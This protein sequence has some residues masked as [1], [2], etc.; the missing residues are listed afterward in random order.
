MGHLPLCCCTSTCAIKE[1]GEWTEENATTC[2]CTFPDEKRPYIFKPA[3]NKSKTFY[4][5]SNGASKEVS[6]GDW[7]NFWFKGPERYKE[8]TPRVPK[9]QAKPNSNHSPNDYID[10]SFLLQTEDEN[11]HFVKLGVEGYLR[12]E[13]NL[14]AFLACC[15]C[16]FVLPN[17]KL[18][19]IRPS[20][21]KIASLMAHGE[22]VNILM[23][24]LKGINAINTSIL[25]GSVN[26]FI[27]IYEEY[28]AM[29]SSSSRKIT[30]ENH[31]KFLSDVQQSLVNSKEENTKERVCME[32]L[33]SNIAKFDEELKLLSTKREKTISCI[34]E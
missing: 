6:I 15:I 8:P 34:K 17:K 30:K 3:I 4:K 27:K 19:H 1:D 10:M 24:D 22:S 23:E 11:V 2:Q 31:Q 29:K 9:H 21:F 32:D 28:N 26:A 25:E 33:Q 13:T 20:I 14:A 16:K 7:V 12:E 18:D 5:L